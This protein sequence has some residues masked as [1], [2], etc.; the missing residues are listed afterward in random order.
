MLLCVIF[1]AGTANTLFA[2]TASIAGKIVSEGKPVA[3]A[4][5]VL[6]ETNQGTV[7]DSYGYFLISNVI[8]GT[9]RIHISYIGYD[10]I[11]RQLTLKNNE[12]VTLTITLVNNRSMLDEVVVT[13]VSKATH[14]RENPVAVVSV[15]SKAITQTTA[16]NII[17]VLVKNA[18]GVNAVKTGPNIS[19]PFIRGLGYNRVLTLYDGIRQEG[20]QWGDEHGIEVDAYN[21]HRAEIIKGPASLMY[22]SDAVAG[23]VSLFPFIPNES[24]GKWHGNVTSEY[25]TNNNMAG[26]GFRLY[27]NK[28]HFLFALRG[29]YRLAKNY[30]NAVDGTVYNTNF[31]EK[32]LSALLG[33]KTSKGYTHVN[34][35]LYD[36]LQGIPDGSRDSLTR[37]FTK[38]INEGINDDIKHRPIVSP[39]E[40][41]T[42][43][44]SPLHQRIQH[45][46]AYIKSAYETGKGNID[47]LFALQQ[48]IRREYNHPTKPQQAGMYVRLNT[49]NYDLHYNTP[50][51]INIETTVGVNGMLQHNKSKDA[52]DFPIPNYN[53]LDA[54]I[55][56]YA[57]WKQKNVTISGG[58]RYDIR[59]VRWNDFY[60]KTDPLTGFNQQ[61]NEQDT[62]GATLQFPA[63]TKSFTGVSASVGF[64][65]HLTN[66]VSIKANVGRGY[67]APNITE[68][69]SNGLDPGAHIFYIGNR[70]FDP[71][72]S[73][74][75]DVGVS[76]TFKAVSAE[77]SLFNNNIQHYIYLTMLADAN[78]N[79]LTDAQGNKTYQYQQAAAQLYGM[80][81]WLAVHPQ[82]ME[83][84]SFNNSL[85]IVYGF[86][87]KQDYKKQDINGEYLPLIPPLKL[88]SNIAQKVK[89]RSKIITMLTPKVEVEFN[90]AQDRFLGLNS[91]E[92]G[93]PG[94]HLINIGWIAEI[95]YL[96]AKTMQ[97]L[98]E[99]NNITNKVYQSHL[100]R[101]KYFE[102]YSQSP[103][104]HTGIY[105]MGRNICMKVILPF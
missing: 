49:L 68:I 90:A 6:A 65:W 70:N 9:Y 47:F 50:K 5:V 37:M 29:A 10:N 103:S 87:K 31:N 64:A 3:L 21:I 54:G 45:Y 73:L 52:T 4:S 105:N 8:P 66:N 60:V 41:N 13:G 101:L 84:F 85:A 7:T 88:V 78:G 58:V 27:Y 24:D 16:G 26:N 48:N 69:A 34:A 56:V 19:K 17:D 59:Q 36:N 81:A 30:R 67:R 96:P 57:K 95:Q 86:N 80:E 44:L 14:V 79:P 72:F 99:V 12:S 102:Y 33:Y 18:P 20:Q 62:T 71:E 43:Q 32:N 38:Q 15:S 76:A 97:L 55:F 46:R 89:L 53:L 104:G 28:T 93:T 98:F 74:Q 75:E 100:N 83:G 51:I 91:T 11:E 92:T 25:Q 40:L 2:Q 42:Y 61:V 23:V 94:Y 35:S 1:F 82:K 63:Y 22:G 39:D 77:V